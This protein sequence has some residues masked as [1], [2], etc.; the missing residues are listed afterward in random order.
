MRARTHRP[1]GTLVALVAGAIALRT[2]P[3]AA[4]PA[5][6]RV[7]S[8][9]AE[10]FR[11][12]VA[13]AEWML[14][15]DRCAWVTSDSIPAALTRAEQQR[16]GPEWFCFEAD[17]HWHAVYGRYDAAAD[18]YDAVVHFRQAAPGGGFTRTGDTVATALTLPYARA[19]HAAAARVPAEVRATG[20][21]F[22]SFVRL[23]PGGAPEVWLLPAW[24]PNGWLLYGAEFR[25][26]F[27]RD[28]RALRDSTARVAPLRG[29]PSD[30][31]R[32]RDPQRGRGRAD[33]RPDVLPAGTV[34]ASRGPRARPGRRGT[35][36]LYVTRRMGAIRGLR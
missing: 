30:T 29:M 35:R 26:A 33:G 2:V 24:Q 8:F 19:L 34:P 27:D 15:Y 3:L 10:R 22:N 14:R 4:Q 9:A 17:G 11:A 6:A 7:G 18:R 32:A 31:A 1:P 20:A 16:L 28:G 36:G 12:N 13:V 21:R 25:Y 5:G 23:G